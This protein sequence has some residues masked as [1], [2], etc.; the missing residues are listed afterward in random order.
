M[1]EDYG[2]GMGPGP[3]AP[4]EGAAPRHARRGRDDTE[5]E[6]VFDR[7]DENGDGLITAAEFNRA[8]CKPELL[9]WFESVGND[10]VAVF[11]RMDSDKG[12][13]G[14]TPAEFYEFCKATSPSPR[15]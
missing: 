8:M 7:I 4:F 6:A 15:T 10:W 12:R 13:E 5:F 9:K 3:G 14:V 2:Y 1:Y 11:N